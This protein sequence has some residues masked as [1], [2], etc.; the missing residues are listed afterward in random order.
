MTSAKDSHAKTTAWHLN[1]YR[2][3]AIIDPLFMH[4]LSDNDQVLDG[5]ISIEE[6]VKHQSLSEKISKLS[7]FFVDYQHRLSVD[8]KQDCISYLVLPSF[9][10]GMW[11]V[12]IVSGIRSQ[13][14][15]SMVYYFPAG[16]GKKN[17]KES[18]GQ[19]MKVVVS[20]ILSKTAPDVNFSKIQMQIVESTET[21]PSP[22]L[23]TFRLL[24]FARSFI[25][26]LRVSLNYSHS[27]FERWVNHLHIFFSRVQ[28][29]GVNPRHHQWRPA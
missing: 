23:D 10:R 5:S 9:S 14:G 13:N 26:S 21:G 11:S 19:L 15:P 17:K 18:I 2:D 8:C 7:G 20:A 29:C 1:L 12:T 28:L 22:A 6:T 27:I 4:F 25:D 16:Y 24:F 3:V